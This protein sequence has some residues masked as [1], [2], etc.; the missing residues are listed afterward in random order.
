MTTRKFLPRW[1]L[2]V[3]KWVDSS[4]TDRWQHITRAEGISVC[5]CESTGYVLVDNE[6][7]IILALSCANRGTDDEQYI[8]TIAIPKVA[9]TKIT[10]I[11]G[12]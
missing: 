4:S 3:I 8:G 1:S 2:A 11:K 10:K 9:V 6:E 12:S 5:E 7:Q